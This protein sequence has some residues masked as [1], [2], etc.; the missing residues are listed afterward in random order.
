M[1]FT[2]IISMLSGAGVMNGLIKNLA[3]DDLNED[4]KNKILKSSFSISTLFSIIISIFIFIFYFKNKSITDNFVVFFVLA[5][6]QFFIGWGNLIQAEASSKQDIPFYVKINIFGGFLGCIFLVSSVSLFGFNGAE[7]GIVINA[8][9]VGGVAVFLSFKRDILSK[10]CGILF[11]YQIYK[12]LFSYSFVTLFGAIAIPLAHIYMRER[13]AVDH[14]WAEVGYWQGVVKV[15]DVYMQLVG[16][17][18]IN[19]ALPKFS[20]EKTKIKN[21]LLKVLIIIFSLLFLIG[22]IYYLFSP[23]II[24]LIF[25]SD[26]LGM[27]EYIMPQLIGD[28]FRSFASAISYYFLSVGMVWV[29]IGYEVLQGIFMVLF[30]YGFHEYWGDMSIVFSHIATY[31]LLFS[32]ITVIFFFKRIE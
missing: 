21:N 3:N 26:F 12:K 25:S 27:R 4:Y 7:I 2:A 5:F 18:L 16:V 9:F 28:F 23:F 13:F 8:A 11:D 31:A 32:I 15:S 19:F 22:C 6:C 14:G 10:V 20:A 1:S 17:I 29:S 30:F 24:G